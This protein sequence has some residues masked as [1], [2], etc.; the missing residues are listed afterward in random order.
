MFDTGTD[1]NIYEKVKSWQVSSIY[2]NSY[3]IEV[4]TQ[5]CGE[6]DGQVNK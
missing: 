1:K 4:E 6:K 3:S 2:E 5:F